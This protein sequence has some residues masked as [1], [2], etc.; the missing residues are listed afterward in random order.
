MV[1]LW[2][3][4]V[5]HFDLWKSQT[6]CFSQRKETIFS[7]QKTITVPAGSG[8]NNYK[9]KPTKKHIHLFFGRILKCSLAKKAVL[10]YKEQNFTPVLWG[11]L[12]ST[13]SCCTVAILWKLEV[14]ENKHGHSLKICCLF[15]YITVPQH[16]DRV[17]Q[18]P[19]FE[20][21]RIYNIHR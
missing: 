10:L 20:G 1:V 3:E 8:H 15:C 4:S 13:W 17:F 2:K 19:T 9:N 6:Q 11:H 12:K 7:F 18:S 14:S 16:R 5:L 21:L